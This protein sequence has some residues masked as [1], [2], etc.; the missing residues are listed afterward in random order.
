MTAVSQQ[1]ILG[2][3]SRFSSRAITKWFLMG[4]VAA[5]AL[6]PSCAVGPRYQRPTEP[7]PSQWNVDQPRGTTSAGEPVEQWWA[8]FNDPQFDKLIRQAIRSNL[9]LKT[10]AARIAE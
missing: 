8:S 7:I 9:D 10:A 2:A 1:S 3:D 5:V 4:L 6:L